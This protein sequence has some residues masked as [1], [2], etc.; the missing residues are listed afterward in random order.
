MP[1]WL[2]VAMAPAGPAAAEVLRAQ[3]RH[4]TV[5]RDERQAGGV[6]LAAAELADE[7]KRH[8]CTRA[9]SG[10]HAAS[11]RSWRRAPTHPAERLPQCLE[12]ASRELA[13]LI[14]KEDA[15]MRESGGISHG[16]A[17]GVVLPLE[18]AYCGRRGVGLSWP[19]LRTR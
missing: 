7:P 1:D 10:R 13:D 18:G 16:W 2:T 6:D 8:G 19:V 12:V 11:R 4:V 14:K 9:S 17:L 3:S 15:T 5:G